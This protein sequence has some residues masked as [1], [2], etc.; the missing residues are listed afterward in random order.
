MSNKTFR[1]IQ[2]VR[3]SN[4]LDEALETVTLP[5]VDPIGSKIRLRVLYTG[6][7]ITDVNLAAGRYFVSGDLPY[8]IGFE[9]SYSLFSTIF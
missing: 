8:D 9:V 4:N 5:L 1:K 6:I 3:P 7:N 2:V